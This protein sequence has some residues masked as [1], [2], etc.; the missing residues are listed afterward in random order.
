MRLLANESPYCVISE[1]ENL[2]PCY[3]LEG[4]ENLCARTLK[5]VQGLNVIEK[6]IKEYTTYCSRFK[7]IWIMEK[8]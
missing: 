7:E 5:I 3:D 1:V 4:I 8:P 6:L 2:L